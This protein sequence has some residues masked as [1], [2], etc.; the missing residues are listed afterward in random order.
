MDADVG[1][2]LFAAQDGDIITI[3]NKEHTMQADISDEEWQRRRE[4]WVAPPLQCTQARAH[5]AANWVPNVLF[6]MQIGPSVS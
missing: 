5:M 6:C 3:D 4:A 1:S 2:L